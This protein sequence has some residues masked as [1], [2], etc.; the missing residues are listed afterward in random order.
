MAQGGLNSSLRSEGGRLPIAMNFVDSARSPVLTQSQFDLIRTV[1]LQHAGLLFEDYKKY[2]VYRRVSTRLKALGLETFDAYC[3]LLKGPEGSGEI[4]L[5]LNTLTT[6]TTDFFRERH[7]FDHL[8]AVVL[9]EIKQQ[10]ATSNKRRIRVWSAGCSTGQE[11][12]SIA[13]TVAQHVGPISGWD[14]KILATDIDTNAIAIA[15][16]ARYDAKSVEA[17]PREVRSRMLRTATSGGESVEMSGELRSLIT[18]RPLNL[19]DAWPMKGPFD[20]IFC[21]NVVIYFDKQNQIRLFD[22]FA[23]MLKDGGYLYIGHSE[24]LFRINDRFRSLG[25][26]IYRKVS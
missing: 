26:S 18:F 22:R 17:I 5:L 11:A 21:R 16:A 1:A 15:R 3:N 25:Q 6:N 19:I 24:T 23:D 2:M 13:D 10:A 9:P 12:Y 7:H 14:A 4:P 8:S 20:A